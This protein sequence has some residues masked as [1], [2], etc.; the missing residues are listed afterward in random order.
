[1]ADRPLKV[2]VDIDASTRGVADVET[3]IGSLESL[4]SRGATAFREVGAAERAAAAHAEALE[5]GV[6]SLSDSLARNVDEQKALW[7]GIAA[8]QNE[9]RRSTERLDGAMR[10]LG[11]RSAAKMQQDIQQV[12][13]ALQRLAIES[14]DAGGEFDRAFAAAQERLR[15][16]RAELDRTP[17]QIDEIR[18][19]TDGLIGLFGR[20]AAAFSGVELATQFVQ[21][22]M[23]LEQAERTFLAIT[24]SVAGAAQ[25]MEY[26]WN[27]AT[28]LALPVRDVASS[29][30][31][32]AA[33]SK[34]SRVEGEQSRAVFE[35]VA[36]AMAVLGRSSDHTAETMTALNQVVSKGVV[37]M[38]ELREQLGDRIPG[39]LGAVAKGVGITT[40]QLVRLVE[41]GR[42]TAEQLFPALAA[43]L[44]DLY[45]AGKPLA[46]QTETLRQAWDRFANSVADTWK[47]IGDAGVVDALKAALQGLD[48]V[49]TTV[50]VGVVATGKDLGIFFAAVANGEIGLRGF[51]AR[52]R[53]AFAEVEREARSKLVDAA[54]HNSL[55]A[56]T[57]DEA[58]KAALAAAR[59]QAQGVGAQSAAGQEAARTALA[60]TRLNVQYGE[61]GDLAEKATKLAQDR[62]QATKAETDASVA[63]AAALGTEREQLAAKAEATQRNAEALRQLAA[64][65]AADLT[66][67][68]RYLAGVQAEIALRGA[69]TEQEQ[70]QIDALRQLVEAKR[71]E[72]DEAAGQAASAA[73]AA[74]AAQAAAA[75]WGDSSRLIADLAVRYREASAAVAELDAQ[76]AAGVDVSASYAQAV[77]AEAQAGAVYRDALADQTAAIARNAAAKSASAAVE[78]AG[79]RLAIEQQRTI[80]EVARARG[81][82][83]RA[84]AAAVEMKRLE[85]RLQ[86]LVADAKRAEAAAALAAVQARREEL[87]ASGQLTAAKEAELRA[88]EAG[89]RVKQV[90]AEIAQET[91]R[92]IRE[93]ADAT[94]AAGSDAARAGD[95]FRRAAGGVR[96]LGGA[97]ADATQ[98]VDALRDAVERPTRGGAF[99]GATE[100]PDEVVRE[101]STQGIDA[102]FLARQQGLSGEAARKFVEA[103]TET[104]ADEVGAMRRKLAGVQLIGT[105]GILAEYGG[106]FDRAVARAK[107][108]A[109]AMARR[110]AATETVPSRRAP[111][112]TD[113]DASPAVAARQPIGNAPP[114]TTYRVEIRLGNRTRVVETA[115]D[116]SAQELL[117][118]LRELQTRSA[119]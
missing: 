66:Q 63:I 30:A 60:V 43:G 23:A 69:A 21:V 110:P 87:A 100:S 53:E 54:R 61:L 71:A 75:S 8:A 78:Q 68:E 96:E 107:E 97:A 99:A 112:R 15:A 118:T 88:Q 50:R 16:L 111:Q 101:V 80:L 28:R 70:R 29:W 84:I 20:L 93:L 105:E 57:L 117:S 77:L 59:A 3:L 37:S 115:D 91:A 104:F 64:E 35:A 2:R 55:L 72:S 79:V 7:S 24:G 76:R 114:A 98:Q 102:D 83:T 18:T 4:G 108:S 10:T 13:Q 67:Q 31:G 44:N 92:R 113:A 106:A 51:S 22:N 73:V 119:A 39:A 33:A 26:A 19:R 34:G 65:R 94:R 5:D 1:M 41:S 62:A 74:A 46:G 90:E 95:G 9:A 40:E 89:A 6:Q 17:G 49:L 56:A 12:N 103:F 45:G 85:A 81:D 58:G 25:E 42:F 32:L 38:E 14:R 52:A 109:E 47:T 116:P 48:V 11:I 36:H 82:E 86:G 27:V